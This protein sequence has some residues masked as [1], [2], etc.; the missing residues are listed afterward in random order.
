LISGPTN[1]PVPDD[2]IVVDHVQTAGEMF[3]VTREYFSQY[4]LAIFTAAVADYTPAHP[5]DQKIKKRGEVM[6]LDLAKT[7]DIAGTLGNEKKD[8]QILIGF[9]LETEH[10][11]DYALDKLRRKNLDYIVLN[12]LNDA[13]SGFAH[14][15]NK[16]TVIDRSENILY[17]PLKSK[18]AA[19]QDILNIILNRWSEA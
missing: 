7:T 5:A 19:A 18:H 4:D 11:M 10:E 1:L 3:D 9:A 12:S 15:T 6:T 2:R 13:G 14:D 8:G 16:I 17:F